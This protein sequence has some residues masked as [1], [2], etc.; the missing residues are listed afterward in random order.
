[1][2]NKIIIIS[3]IEILFDNNYYY[4]LIYD[5]ADF[6]NSGEIYASTPAAMDIKPTAMINTIKY[7]VN[8]GIIWTPILCLIKI[9]RINFKDTPTATTAIKINIGMIKRFCGNTVT[10]ERRNPP[11]PFDWQEILRKIQQQFL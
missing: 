11:I 6:I 4:L 3:K 8:I 2:Q 10:K 1:M 7:C 5:I 9:L